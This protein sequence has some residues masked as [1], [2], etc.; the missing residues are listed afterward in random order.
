[1]HVIEEIRR[2]FRNGEHE[3]GYGLA[4]DAIEQGAR[5]PS[6]YYMRA[7]HRAR[8]EEYQEALADFEAACALAP[9][10]PVLL[11]ATGHCLTMLGRCREAVDAFDSAIAVRPDFVRAHYRKGI[12][13]GLLNEIDDM[14]AAHRRVV[15]L[16]PL[17]ADA[18]ASLAFIAARRGEAGEART[19]GERAAQI[20]PRHNIAGVAL[21][22][23]DIEESRYSAAQER[24]GDVLG[25]TAARQDG[26]LNMA[27]GFAADALDRHGRH[28]DA[29]HLYAEINARR[30]QIHEARFAGDRAIEQVSKLV[31][32]TKHCEFPAAET[33][34]G[35]KAGDPAGHIFLLG[36]VRSGTTLLETV[37]A[38]NP[39]VLASDERDF[40]ANA[41]NALLHGNEDLRQLAVLAPDGLAHWRTDYWNCVRGAGLPVEGKAFV[42]KVPL[43]SLRLPLIARLFPN[44]GIVFAVRDPRDVVLSTFRHRFNMY[45]ASFEFLGL[46]DCARFYAAVMQLVDAVRQKAPWL[47]VCEIRYEDLVADFDRTIAT[48]CAFV[49]IEWN[50]TMRKFQNAS[51]VIDRRS[52]SAAQV[53][54]GLY[55]GAIGHWRH[56][57][58]QLAP[59][60]PILAPWVGRFGYRQD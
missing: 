6:L 54:C 22:M 7:L 29:F 3:R 39:C 52:Q 24:L 19:F 38:S 50:E 56:Y 60:M 30:R 51:A 47:P 12:A 17:N 4:H 33:P 28:P 36:F 41:A 49:G 23:A 13:L 1:M 9:R 55:G 32:A 10:D 26:R 27:L 11:E 59:V 25:D 15:E 42:D 37:L 2:A 43:N 48:V 18:L 35:G 21:A 40:L 31:E 58:E 44:A 8:R 45:P 34:P 14:R 20:T 57:A 5:H 16:E 46:E 53:R